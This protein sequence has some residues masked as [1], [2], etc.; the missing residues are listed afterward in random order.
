MD[1]RFDLRPATLADAEGIV[2]L[3]CACDVEEV[4]EPD[5]DL[6]GLDAEWR[7]PGVDPARDA[8]VAVEPDGRIA[9]Y[10]LLTGTYVRA[11]THPEQRGRG[12]G[13]A[14]RERAEARAVERGL[15]EVRQQIVGGNEPARALLTAAGYAATAHHWRMATELGAAHAPPP[16]PPEG[17]GVRPF[18]AGADDRVA[19]E[20]LEGAFADVEGQQAR[21]FESWSSMARDQ[22]LWLV[23][24]LDG[25]PAGALAAEVREEGTGYVSELGVRREARRRGIAGALLLH[26]FAGFAGRGMTR[27]ALTVRTH[28]LAGVRLYE[29]LGMAPEWRIDELSKRIG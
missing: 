16:P 19:H 8:V 5:Y 7:D 25:A 14:I 10:A 22:D 13:T 28:N 3:V 29:S 15:P 6:E 26:A 27:A 4:G 20:I 17:V 12:V 21:T 18:A 1:A 2:A 23:A 24:E 11:W 9:G